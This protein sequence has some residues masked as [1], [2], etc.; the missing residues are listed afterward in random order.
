MDVLDILIIIVLTIVVYIYMTKQNHETFKIDIPKQKEI[1]EPLIQF[2]YKNDTIKTIEN[3]V[4]LRPSELDFP[5]EPRKQEN[6]YPLEQKEE[7]E[8]NLNKLYNSATEA[9]IDE[10]YDYLTSI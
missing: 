7:L 9:N 4:L 6:V 8:L 1:V 10:L 5:Y 3:N 2:D